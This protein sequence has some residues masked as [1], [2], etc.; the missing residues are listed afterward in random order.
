MHLHVHARKQLEEPGQHP[1]PV[2]SVRA[3]EGIAAALSVVVEANEAA[4]VC[5]APVK[6]THKPFPRH[7]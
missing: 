2:Q 4:Q 7:S 6:C 3:I 1:T 5:T